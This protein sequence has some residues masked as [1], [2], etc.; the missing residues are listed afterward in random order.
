MRYA[1]PIAVA[2]VVVLLT[3]GFALYPWERG[4]GGERELTLEQWVAVLLGAECV[5]DPA[6]DDAVIHMD[7]D[8]DGV[9]R[10]M[11]FAVP[12][13]VRARDG[14]YIPLV[15]GPEDGTPVGRFLDACP[16]DPLRFDV[17]S[18]NDT[19]LEI[20]AAGWETS[21]AAVL[22]ANYTAAVVSG[23]LA[24]YVGCP[25]LPADP[26]ID[27]A[28]RTVLSGLGVRYVVS[29][30]ADPV[31]GMRNLEL[32]VDGVNDLYLRLLEAAGDRSDYIVVTNTR[33]V[34]DYPWSADSMPVPGISCV[35]GELAA[36][37][38]AVI[39]LAPGY[40]S[41]GEESGDGYTLLGVPY[42]TALS[43][44]DRIDAAI[45]DALALL[46]AHG[47]AGEYVAMVGGP[48]S[49][50]FHYANMTAYTEE[51]QY[52][53]SD[54]RY[55]NTDGDPEQELSIGRIVGRTPWSASVTVALT[56]AFDE[57]AGY[58]WEDDSS[59]LLYSTVTDDWRENSLMV[60]GTTKIGPG[61]GVLTPTLVNQ[62]RTMTEA[63]FTVTSLGYDLAT[64]DTI[65]E[66]IDEMNYDV[67]YGHGTID[68]WY[69]T[70]GWAFDAD[71]VNA[72]GLK[73]GFAI[74]M[75]CL[76]GLIDSLD[77]PLDRF[78]SLAM[79]NSGAAGYIGSTRVAYGLYDVEISGE[80]VIRGTGALYLVDIFSR[81]ACERDA[82]VG[83]ALRNAKNAL[84]GVQGYDEEEGSAGFEAA[85]TVNEY[86]LY[87]DPAHNL[88]IPD[89]DG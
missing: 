21:E 6:V 81:E 59:H 78:F 66:I 20:A 89:H 22:V 30:G 67:Y 63:G 13:A 26:G 24:A 37:R 28:L 25:I 17:F 27:A 38:K 80:N 70:V 88:W 32:G 43:V 52:T 45:D 64:G 77:V 34:E 55:A 1:R 41:W 86:V 15:A 47:F 72:V 75:A 65:R 12:L 10:T 79:L 3:A 18:A 85:I 29:V 16:R 33:D 60:I 23:P 53:P 14:G 54:Y 19:A 50:P 35:A 51:R 49:L 11:P 87:G 31:P 76:T 84:I 8:R 82:D 2:L 83:I 71:Q 48:I 46:D 69:S 73:P 42:R 5:R 58:T 36:A 56:L 61:P 7:G 74:A 68:S 40:T 4:S 62:T 39:A 44:S 57:A 9:L